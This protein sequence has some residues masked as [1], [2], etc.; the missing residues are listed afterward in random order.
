MVREPQSKQIHHYR[1]TIYGDKT[2]P[3]STLRVKHHPSGPELPKLDQSFSLQRLLNETILFRCRERLLQAQNLLER[4]Q[5][6]PAKI[7]RVS[8]RD[9]I[10]ELERQ[11]NAAS[12]SIK[13]IINLLDRLRIL[14]LMERLQRAIVGLQIEAFSNLLEKTNFIW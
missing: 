5:P 12:P 7:T 13:I 4:A 14:I 3:H 9:E 2:D 10:N 8:R 11:L 6:K 1:F